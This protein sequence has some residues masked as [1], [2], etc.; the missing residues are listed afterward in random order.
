MRHRSTEA[1]IRWECK[2]MAKLTR[3]LAPLAWAGVLVP[4]ASGQSPESGPAGSSKDYS[5]SSIVTR[6]M[7]FDKNQDG[8]L[9]KDEVTDPRLHRL[10]DR[11]DTNR[12]GVVT[13]QEL[14]ALAAKP[15]AEAPQVRGPGGRGFGPPPGGG[16]FGEPPDDGPGGP[17]FRGPGRGGPGGPPGG[18]PGRFA[19]PPRPGQ[20][21]PPF[22]QER[23][24]L[25]GEQKREL[26]DL[27]KQVD[28]RLAKILTDEQKK[29][30]HEMRAGPG[31]RGFGRRGPGGPPE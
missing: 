18:G 17:G 2:F 10:F 6:M 28:D 9:T 24:N 1:F 27:Q 3:F 13:R 29:Q 23:L 14:A 11:A 25:T 20:I 5:N 22:V 19:G 7:K 30:L 26:Q 8:K 12:D 31:G 15:E 4:L 21:L 16:D